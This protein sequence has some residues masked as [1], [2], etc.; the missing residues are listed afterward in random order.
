MRRFNSYDNVL[1]KPKLRTYC[2][3]KTTYCVEGYLNLDLSRSERSLLAQF[4]LGILPLRIETG[5]FRGEALNTRTC[6]FCDL[7]EIEDE[8]HFIFHCSLY[9]DIRHI[10]LNNVRI[11]CPEFP[12]FNDTRKLNHIM[13]KHPRLVSKFVSRAFNR[14]RDIL[15]VQT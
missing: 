7:N 1:N 3:F 9:N 8:P 4:R 5:R 6:R 14:R 12:T 15:Y 10:L 2:T 11:A 13:T